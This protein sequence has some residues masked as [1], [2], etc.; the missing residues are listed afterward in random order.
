MT[1]TL[2]TLIAATIAATTAFAAPAIPAY[3]GGQVS[4]SIVPQD[5]K[6]KDAMKLGLGILGAVKGNVTQNGNGNSAGLGQ[7]GGGNNGVIVQD[8]NGHNGTLVQNNG[9]NSHGLFQFGEGTNGHV[10]Q[11][12]GE[13]ST[14]IQFGWK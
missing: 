5:Q 10:T 11:N 6:H 9:G 7:G 2:K 3:A 4:I 13:T 14:T 1:R 8:G 12:G